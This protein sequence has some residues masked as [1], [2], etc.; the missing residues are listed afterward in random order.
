MQTEV[1]EEGDGEGWV[2]G[3][4]DGAG[5]GDGVT[6]DGAGAGEVGVLVMHCAAQVRQ[7][8]VRVIKIEEREREKA[9]RRAF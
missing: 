8:G 2:T 1:P 3:D 4:G 5:V 9:L 7:W 6:G